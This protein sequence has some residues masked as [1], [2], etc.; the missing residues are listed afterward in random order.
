VP[1]P[2]TDPDPFPESP[3]AGPERRPRSRFDRFGYTVLR[4]LNLAGLLLLAAAVCTADFLST[5]NVFWAMV[6][7]AAE[8]ALAL[9]WAWTVVSMDQAEARLLDAKRL[10]RFRRIASHAATFAALGAV[11]LTKAIV[12]H[13][14]T[15]AEGLG[16]MAGPYRTYIA[17]AF[18][19]FAIG[20]V[21]RGT[22][23]ARFLGT[24]ADHPA[25]LMAISFALVALLGGFVL[26]LPVS[27][28]DP[29]QASFVD[30]LF[31]SMSAVCV[32]GLAVNDISATYTGFGQFVILALVQAGGLGIMVLTAAVAILAG[33]RFQAKSTQALTEMIDAE[34]FATLRRTIRHIFV[35]TVVIEALGAFLLYHAFRAHPEMALGPESP[36]PLAGAGSVAW[37]AVF[38]SVSAFCNAGFSLCHGNLISFTGS[39]PVSGVVSVLIVLGGLGFPV[40]DELWQRWKERKLDVPSRKLSLHTRVVVAC[41]AMLI[42]VGALALLELEWNETLRD[43]PLGEKILA[44]TFASVTARTAGF[45]TVNYGAMGAPALV[46]TCFLMFIGASPGS[47]GGGIKTTTFTVLLAAFRAEI[48]GSPTA[49][50]FDRAIPEVVARKAA[51]VAVGSGVLVATFWFLLLLTETHGPLQLL[52]ETVSAFATCGLSTGITPVLSVAGKVLVTLLMFTGRIGIMTLALAFVARPRVQHFRVAEERVLIG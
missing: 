46:L 11:L 7:T 52:F 27:L 51:A 44:A 20:L 49:H 13:R 18:V 3:F 39:L 29:N 10:G 48:R 9:P 47:T 37:S 1:D 31:T 24:L 45:N 35:F 12:L 19:L 34:S 23:L 50:V 14:A 40:M 43:R 15:E 5:G 30:G 32:T 25:R 42:V 4:R 33:R 6:L 17:F 36:H 26:T 38:H 22:R 8:A 28:R 2:G 16:P 21:G 41:T